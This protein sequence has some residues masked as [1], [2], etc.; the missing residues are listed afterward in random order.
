[1]KL[2]RQAPQVN[3]MSCKRTTQWLHRLLP[4]MLVCTVAGAMLLALPAS[5]QMSSTPSVRT[6]SGTVTDSS[7]EPIRGAVVEL[8]NATSNQMTSYLTD[9][10][11]HYNFKRLNG[12]ADYD[13]RVIF[14]GRHSST[15][16]ISKFDS[17]MVK[18]INFT[19]RTY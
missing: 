6:L 1:M 14:R 15:R 11:G 16:D 18:V 7:H 19:L 8:R 13:V 3:V 12:N 5:A 2:A 17:H 4:A 9:A 10:N